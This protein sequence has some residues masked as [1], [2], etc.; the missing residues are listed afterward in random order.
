MKAI[1]IAAGQGSRLRPHTSNKPKCM[2]EIQGRSLIERQV[3]SFRDSGIDDIVV[4]RGYRGKQ[5][6]VPGV[7]YVDNLNFKQNN[8]LESL[9]CA[10][11]E[12]VGDVLISYGDIMYHSDIVKALITK[13]APSMLVVDLDWKKVYEDRDDHPVEQAELCVIDELMYE[14]AAPGVVY[15]VA[16]VGKHI[17]EDRG[18]GEFIGLA[19]FSA[20]AIA[21]MI[22]HYEKACLQDPNQPYQNAPSLRQ[23]YLTDLLNASIESGEFIHPLWIK[24]GW[25]EIDTVQDY[26]R[27]QAEVT[28]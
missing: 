28:W 1:I 16:E 7:R 19:R 14:G 8:I 25:R 10:R 20:A 18:V 21:R 23:A 22:A 2:V 6:Q 12:L 17:G 13:T 24:G 5:I 9:F 4:I 11:D 26:E 15:R 27:A 3:Q